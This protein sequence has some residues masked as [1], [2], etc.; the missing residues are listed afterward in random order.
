MNIVDSSGWLEY[1]ADGSNADFFAP[2]IKNTAEL[3]IP[4]I[5]VYEVFKR[6]NQQR[7]DH[8]ALQASAIMTQGHV[9]NLDVTLA[10]NAAKISMD[11]HLPM[12]DS[13]ILATARIYDAV[14]WT[15]DHDFESIDNVRYISKK[16][17]IKE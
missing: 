8:D 17:I 9:V 11:L 16:P 1:F 12:A 7:S 15:Q 3:V 4:T 5:C 6:I 13:I 14:I 10:L 2:A